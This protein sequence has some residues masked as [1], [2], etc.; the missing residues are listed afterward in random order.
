VPGKRREREASLY[1]YLKLNEA[2]SPAT[3]SAW[4]NFYMNY[5]NVSHRPIHL[6]Y[7]K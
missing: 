1:N 2:L 5:W 6:V 3:A 7:R 4:P